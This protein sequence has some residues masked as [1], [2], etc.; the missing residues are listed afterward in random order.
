MRREEDDAHHSSSTESDERCICAGLEHVDVAE[1]WGV[2]TSDRGERKGGGN[3][4][5][6]R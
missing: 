1:G 2:G 6:R 4:G 5:A 3:V